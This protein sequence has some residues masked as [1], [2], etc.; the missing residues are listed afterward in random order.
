MRLAWKRSRPGLRLQVWVIVMDQ[1]GTS[2]VGCL[3][4]A[5]TMCRLAKDSDE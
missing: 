1:V 4:G 5:V 2:G 3:V